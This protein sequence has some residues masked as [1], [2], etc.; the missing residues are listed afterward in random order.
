M[1]KIL[2]DEALRLVNSRHNAHLL[3]WQANACAELRRLHAENQALRQALSD[4]VEQPAQQEPVA[5]PQGWKLVP[6][7][8]TE[9]MQMAGDEV[10]PYPGEEGFG[11]QADT[12]TIYR[13][14][15]DA[16][17]PAPAQ[18]WVGLTVA[19]QNELCRKTGASRHQ[20]RSVEAK[21]KEKN[22]SAHGITKGNT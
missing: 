13:A 17:P 16:T 22:T 9:E 5:V 20:V 14:M 21:L 7:E 3:T 19:E 15:L 4:S 2:I 12:L 10:P 1:S 11:S 18:S 8:P 6:L